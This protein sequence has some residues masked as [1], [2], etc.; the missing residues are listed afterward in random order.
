M[1]APTSSS[2]T[3]GWLTTLQVSGQAQGPGQG[4]TGWVVGLP[5]A[6]TTG[7]TATDLVNQFSDSG[8]SAWLT[9]DDQSILDPLTQA[10]GNP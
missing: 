5:T 2:T 10:L 6:G 3:N 4:I 1:L 9:R 7:Q 8:A